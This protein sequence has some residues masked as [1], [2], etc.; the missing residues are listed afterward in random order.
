MTILNIQGGIGKNIA[1]TAVVRAMKEAKPTEEIIILTAYPDVF[2]GNPHIHRIIEFGMGRYMYR[3]FIK[4]KNTN[5]F[6]HDPYFESSHVYE[7]KHLIDTWCSM[8]GI[9]YNKQLPQVFLTPREIEFY[10][11]TI[12]VSEKPLMVIQANGGAE[13]Q[14]VKY[15]WARDIPEHVVNKVI[16][17]FSPTN[18]IVVIGRDDQIKY[19]NTIHFTNTFRCVASLLLMSQK[20]LLIDSF[21]QHTCAALNLPSVVCWISN[22]PKV[23]GYKMHT[24]IQAAEYTKDVDCRLSVLTQYDFTGNPSEF[25]YNNEKEIFNVDEIISALKAQDNLKG[26]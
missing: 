20:R 19:H 4:D 1:A 15:S 2:D 14:A 10:Q 13:N 6:W 22:K 24:N 26:V 12:G 21:A 9:K 18:T 17:E 11:K 3:D 8:F 23:F 25:P 7:K 5:I 16:E